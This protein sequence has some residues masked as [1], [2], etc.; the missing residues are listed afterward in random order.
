MELRDGELS[1]L[2][3][4]EQRR[5]PAQTA[6]LSLQD[7]AGAERRG[8]VADHR[9]SLGGEEYA[10]VR[11]L[12]GAQ[13]GGFARSGRRSVT[14]REVLQPLEGVYRRGLVQDD[15]GAVLVEHVAAPAVD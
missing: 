10:T 11:K 5:V 12:G 3:H 6:L 14:Q 2:G 1:G 9:D 13:L 4:R 8:V 15:G 7:A